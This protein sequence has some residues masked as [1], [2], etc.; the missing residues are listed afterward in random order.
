MTPKPIT[1]AA[2]RDAKGYSRYAIAMLMQ[3]RGI[4]SRRTY[5]TWESHEDLPSYKYEAAM[6]VIR[7]LKKK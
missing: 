1:L 6:K 2:A 7:G 3:E 4:C 5:E